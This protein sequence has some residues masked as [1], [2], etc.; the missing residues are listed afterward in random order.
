MKLR[1]DAYLTSI[2]DL[3]FRL[4]RALG[5]RL[6]LCDVDNSLQEHGLHGIS[7]EAALH[8]RAMH[9]AGLG[10]AVLTNAREERAG[11][12]AKAIQDALPGLR[13]PVYAMAKKPSRKRV[14]EACRDA[15]TAP[16]ETLL[17]G[18][19]YF[20]DALAGL[21]AGLGATVLLK[22]ISGREPWYIRLKRLGERLLLPILGIR[23]HDNR[24]RAL[25]GCSLLPGTHRESGLE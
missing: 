19:Q 16:A 7:P 8:F 24:I 13:I 14:L 9:A 6:I 17:F 18:D 22:P 12:M 2:D 10:M 3:D 20:T 15:G 21:R 23:L 5:Y 4:I 25:P 11:A 1:V